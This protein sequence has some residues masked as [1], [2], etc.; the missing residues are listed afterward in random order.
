MSVRIINIY[1]L[2]MHEYM[3]QEASSAEQG[4]LYISLLYLTATR[5]HFSSENISELKRTLLVIVQESTMMNPTFLAALAIVLLVIS[6]EQCQ[7][8]GKMHA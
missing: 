8:S 1:H 2:Y 6:L 7:V 5:L 3:M 4:W